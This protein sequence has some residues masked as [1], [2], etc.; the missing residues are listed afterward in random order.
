MPPARRLRSPI[1]YLGIAAL[2]LFLMVRV[3][4]D[5]FSVW[6]TAMAATDFWSRPG[7]RLLFD[8][9]QVVGWPIVCVEM[10]RLASQAW[11]TRGEK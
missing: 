5:L 3:A 4:V 10:L 6:Q 9:V 1:F 11:R 2:S 8:A 7:R